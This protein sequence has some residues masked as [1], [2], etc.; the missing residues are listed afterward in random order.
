MV[1]SITIGFSFSS[2]FSS[3]DSSTMKC[4]KEEGE[5]SLS[6]SL[7]KYER[8]DAF[9]VAMRYIKD[10]SGVLPTHPGAQQG[11]VLRGNPF[12]SVTPGLHT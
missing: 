11:D 4:G 1:F 3:K 12:A 7:S 10:P 8:L 9:M 5:V 6:E 2:C